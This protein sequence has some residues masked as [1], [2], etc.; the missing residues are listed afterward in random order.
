MTYI[1]LSDSITQ[2]KIACC[3]HR[4]ERSRGTLDQIPR[5]LLLE[6][7]SHI[8]ESTSST[9]QAPDDYPHTA[10]FCDSSCVSHLSLNLVHGRLLS[11]PAV[12]ETTP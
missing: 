9:F 11:V 2:S 6:Y 4:F 8:G 10:L 5:S 12:A 7:C 1:K 3:L